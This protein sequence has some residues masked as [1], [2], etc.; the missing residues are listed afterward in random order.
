[1]EKIAA[2]KCCNLAPNLE[3]ACP[4]K[5]YVSTNSCEAEEAEGRYRL[6]RSIV[7]AGSAGVRK[8]EKTGRVTEGGTIQA[9]CN[10]KVPLSE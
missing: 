6:E 9:I 2:Y 4:F 8:C 3:Y 5:E 10:S 1:M 7:I